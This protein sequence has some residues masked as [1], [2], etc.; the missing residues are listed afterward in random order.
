MKKLPMTDRD[1][2]KAVFKGASTTEYRSISD[3]FNLNEVGVMLRDGNFSE[4]NRDWL[5]NSFEYLLDN[6][7]ME[8]N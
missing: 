3:K 8:V 6:R 5:Y 1:L 2:E 4:R 7:P